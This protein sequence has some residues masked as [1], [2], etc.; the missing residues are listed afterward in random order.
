MFTFIAVFKNCGGERGIRTLSKTAH[1]LKE[2]FIGGN[3]TSLSVI[4]TDGFGVVY[5]ELLNNRRAVS[6]VFHQ[7][8]GG[9]PEAVE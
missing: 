8:G 2:S 4:L 6:S 3:A 7:A 5:E 9:V 1:P